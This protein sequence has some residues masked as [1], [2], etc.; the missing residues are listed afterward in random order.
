MDT[1][2]SD[3]VKIELDGRTAEVPRGTTILNAAR[4]MGVTIP[5]LCNYRGLSPYGACRVCLVELQTPRG[6]QL[7]ASCS[8]PIEI[9]LVVKTETPAVQESRRTV[10]ELL[11]AQAPDSKEL[12]EFA[13]GLG[14]HSTPFQPEADGKCVLCGLCT[15]VCSEMMGRGAINLFGRGADREVRTAFA[16]QTNQCQA[17]GACAFVCPTGAIDLST[18]TARRLQPHVTGFDKYLSARPCIDLAHPQATP[19][20]PVID[21]ENCI[22]FKS[23]QCGLC[24]KVCQAGAIDYDQAEEEIS[25]KVGSVVLTPGFEAFDATRRGEFGFGFA[26]NVLTNVQF[27]RLLSASGPTRGHVVRPSDGQAPKRIAFIQCIGSRDT[28]CDNDYCSSVCCMAATKEAI[29]AKEHVPG[30]E[31]TIFFLDLRA[32]GKDFDRYSDRAKNQLGIRYQRSFI[33]RTYEMPGTRNLRVI[34]ATEDKKGI[35]PISGHERSGIA[36]TE[37]EFDMIVLS[38]GLEPSATLREQA[39]RMGVVLNRWGFAQTSEFAP[40]DTTRPGVFVGGAFQEPKDIPDTVMQA[41]AAAARAMA[42]LA[43]SRGTRVRVKTYPAHRDI[44]DEPPRVG[45]FICH[46]GSNIASVVDVERVVKRTRELPNVVVA[47]NN[48]YTCADDTQNRIKER[49][50]EFRLNRVVVASCTPRTHE[51]IF[52]DTLRD[53]GLNPYLLEMANIRDQCSWVHSGQPGKATDKAVDLVRMA[54]GRASRLL[55]LEEATVPVKNAALVVGGGI[56]GMTAALALAEQGFPVHLVEKSSELGGT[57][58][59]IHRTL[60]GQD[61]QAFLSSTIDRINWHSRI[62]VYVNTKVSKVQGHLGSFHSKLSTP[63]G[64]LEV[65]H[66]VVVVATGATELKPQTYGYGQSPQVATQLDLAERLASGNLLLPEQPTIAMIQCVEQRN[67]DRPYCSRVCCT[68][69]VKNALL[70]RERYPKAR[71]LV[72][73]RDMRTYGFREA[74]YR[75]AREKGILFVRYEPEQP[76]QVTAN[77][78]LE[79]RVREPALGRD[80]Q[81]QPDLLVLAAPMVPRADREEISELLRVPLNADGFFVE[82]HMK[83]RPVDFASEGLFLCGTAHAPKFIGESIAQANAVAGRAAS[84]LAKKKMPVGGQTAWVDSDKCISCMTCVH[85]C[86]YMAPQVN[87]FNKAEVQGATC[88]GCGSCT[89]EC[90]AKAI[91]LRHY[92]DSQILA[93]LSGLLGSQAD[94]TPVEA[95]YPEQAG[96]APPRWHKH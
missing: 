3:R 1:T 14:V 82:A 30:L 15:R 46:C 25:L 52:R 89:A 80:L 73:Y 10:V 60:D 61:V 8:Y 23:D 5:T 66:G 44:T 95:E 85:V 35:S 11:L 16:E 67:G 76:P 59:Q 92:V 21:R 12:K 31:V 2:A 24:S 87:E 83:L 32:F 55:P 38:L 90:P 17:C 81:I 9:N 78:K 39:D 45:V 53:A 26:P 58:R 19:R 28:A 22:H 43:P 64:E 84:I 70:L 71:I 93:A 56:A 37:E 4:Q 50:A 18:I 96:V 48:T 69:A 79:L 42:L 40:M 49:I 74:A 47:E 41:S 63:E 77:G 72:L 33:S 13:A 54:V 36:Q 86:P 51:P 88:M 27:E 91:T 94:E 29:L 62:H 6:G 68:S 65:E 75:E 34:Y 57:L 20:V 7:V